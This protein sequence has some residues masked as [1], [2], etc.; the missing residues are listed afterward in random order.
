MTTRNART[1]KLL[2]ALSKLGVG[3]SYVRRFALPEWWDDEIAESPGGCDDLHLLLAQHLGL[4]PVSLRDGQPRFAK[5]PRSKLKTSRD[6][7]E[8]DVAVAWLIGTQ[9][10]RLVALGV[11]TPLALPRSASEARNAILKSGRTWVD[12]DALL[13]YCW[14]VGIAVMHISAFPRG[15]RRM[16]ALVSIIDGRPI[17]VVADGRK[18]T[19]WILFHVAHEL[20]H[21]VLGHVPADVVLIDDDVDKASRD[22]E[23]RQANAFA[24]EL[25]TG[26][27]YTGFHATGRLLRAGE[28]AKAALEHG[29]RYGVDPQHV[30]LN[31][32][33]K[34]GRSFFAVANAALWILEPGAD[35]P[36]LIRQK[37]AASLDWSKLPRESAEF[38]LRVTA[39]STPAA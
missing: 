5:L 23:E 36:A 39:A 19:G 21:V 37:F 6:T 10:A 16:A 33:D 14:S 25:L 9:V 2:A 35:A 20:G 38:V 34:M 18:G 13:D 27:A 4:D 17:I 22:V 7:T 28:L 29:R 30:V 3:Q 8:A 24:I 1:G 32:A 12:L 11:G 15:R 26:D 31:Y